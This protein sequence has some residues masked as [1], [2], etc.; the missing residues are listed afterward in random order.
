MDFFS[1]YFRKFGDI[2]CLDCKNN[3]DSRTLQLMRR[4]DLVVIAVHQNY[5]E[6]C[7]LFFAGSI[8]FA[9]C[10]WLVVDY[11][12]GTDFSLDR[13][14]FEFRIPDSRMLC[15]P[16]EPEG[17][18]LLRCRK[19][20]RNTPSAE[21]AGSGRFDAGDRRELIRSARMMLRALGF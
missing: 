18:R 1:K 13:I 14:S 8:R 2:Q 21:D 4:A 16:Y 19:R 9:N 3:R 12:S 7:D 17:K 20:M 10:V 15:I 5:R 11:I 6:I